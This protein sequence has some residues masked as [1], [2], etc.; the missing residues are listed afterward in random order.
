MPA[1]RAP[2]FAV[3]AVSFVGAGVGGDS[4][5]SNALRAAGV[6]TILVRTGDLTGVA[7][8]TGVANNLLFTKAIFLM[9]ND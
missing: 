5:K 3:S 7:P 4:D 1:T 2:T 9:L 8:S 6:V